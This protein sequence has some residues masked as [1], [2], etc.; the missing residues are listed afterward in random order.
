M[1]NR[2]QTRRGSE[3]HPTDAERAFG[4]VVEALGAWGTSGQVVICAISTLIPTS[5]CTDSKSA[6]APPRLIILNRPEV[7]VCLFVPGFGV[8]LE[9][10]VDIRALADIC[11]GYV[12]VREAIGRGWLTLLGARHTCKDFSGWLGTAHYASG[13]AS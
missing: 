11:L 4:P 5:L 9:V 3:S 6:G 12:T 13:V 10:L 7:D 8:D 2:S 1:R